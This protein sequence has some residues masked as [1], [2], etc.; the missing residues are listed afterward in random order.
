MSYNN[1][2]LPSLYFPST[3]LVKV[4]N[5]LPDQ[6]HLLRDASLFF[7]KPI[8]PSVRDVSLSIYFVINY[9]DRVTCW[10]VVPDFAGTLRWTIDKHIFMPILFTTTTLSSLRLSRHWDY[11]WTKHSFSWS[12]SANLK[13][14]RVKMTQCQTR[15]PPPAP[16]LLS[17]FYLYFYYNIFFYFLN[18][19]SLALLFWLVQKKYRWYE[20]FKCLVLLKVV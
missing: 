8:G 2:W 4:S 19:F 14:V 18:M 5:F 10:T 11:L 17:R 20:N 1:K 13:N 7:S 12:S 9:C 6:K 15:R 3:V 16:P